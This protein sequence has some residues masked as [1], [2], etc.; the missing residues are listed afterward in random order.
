MEIM[1][2]KVVV[3]GDDHDGPNFWCIKIRCTK[4]QYDEGT[5]YERAM[6][7]VAEMHHI[8]AKIAFDEKD[9][10]GGL[11]GFTDMFRWDL[12]DVHDIT[13]HP[14][15]PLNVRLAAFLDELLR[16][17][18]VAI[19]KL[20]SVEVSCNAALLNH[21]TVQVT[22]EGTTCLLSILNGFFGPTPDGRNVI[23]TEVSKQ[24]ES[25]EYKDII[26]FFPRN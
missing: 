17:D 15:K 14:D 22:P 10:C 1:T 8:D 5:H 24:P 9:K 25:T 21:P 7:R 3:A 12:A 6:Q 23:C 20:F 13:E 16:V 19:K 2:I 26:K 18:P 4:E 11:P